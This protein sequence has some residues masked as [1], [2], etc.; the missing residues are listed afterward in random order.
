[1]C[2]YSA[3]EIRQAFQTKNLLARI[4]PARLFCRKASDAL[5]TINVSC[6]IRCHW[7]V[8]QGA[9]TLSCKSMSV[10]PF[11]PLYRPNHP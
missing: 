9:D 3:E 2:L 11:G 4:M 6:L 8:D 5:R 1:M 7:Q 10:P